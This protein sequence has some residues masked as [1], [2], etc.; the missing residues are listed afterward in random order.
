MGS[1]EIL[2]EAGNIFA[3]ESDSSGG[4]DEDEAPLLRGAAT[5]CALFLS[6]VVA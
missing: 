4:Y 6:R 5:L 3:F 1:R 2:D